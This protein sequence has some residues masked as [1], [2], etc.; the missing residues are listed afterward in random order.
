MQ[1]FLFFLNIVNYEEPIKTKIRRLIMCQIFICITMYSIF[2]LILIYL[3]SFFHLSPTLKIE[4]QCKI[5]R[6]LTKTFLE[7]LIK[8]ENLHFGGGNTDWEEKKLGK[9]K[10]SETR[11]VEI[12]EH[13]CHS[14]DKDDRFRCHSLAET[15]E[16]L[17]E[18]WFYSRQEADPSL[19][20]FL[21]VKMLSYCCDFGYFG[22]K[23]SPCPGFKESGKSCFGRGL[24]DGEGNKSGNGTCSCHRGYT[25]KSC[26]NCD[27]SSFPISQNSTFI[28]CHE[29]FDGCG[30]GCTYAGPKG[31]NACRTGYKMTDDGCQDVDEC[32]ETEGICQKENEICVNLQ[33]SY[34]CQCTE[35]FKRFE[36]GNCALDIKVNYSSS[37]FFIGPIQLLRLIAY[38]SLLMISFFPLV[39][40]LNILTIFVVALIDIYFYLDDVGKNDEKSEKTNEG[41][42][43]DENE[44]KNAENKDDKQ[45]VDKDIQDEL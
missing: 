32:K 16:E 28:E 14:E 36:S 31:C 35:G 27:S 37:P 41:E 17:L 43:T 5:C 25:G 45:T 20:I 7:G 23:C 8:T 6:V 40:A 13:I 38:L 29:C 30:S 4:D 9:F 18:E 12:M 24:C 34:E 26:N 33:G 3:F 15:N 21:C 19:E 1:T 39:I 10:T 42:G 2:F 44:N 22:P 11:F